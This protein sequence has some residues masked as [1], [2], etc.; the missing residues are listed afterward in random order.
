MKNRLPEYYE[1]TE[2]EIKDIWNNGTILL[3][4]N[5][6][7]NLFRYSKT[8]REEL[9]KIIKH[10]QDR[11]WLPYQVAFEFLE[12]AEGVPAS[13]SKALNETLK[14]IDALYGTIESQLKL[15]EYDKYHLLRPT[16]L[17][18]DIKKFQDAL[19]KRVEKIRTE[20]NDID[21]KAIVSEVTDIFSGKV[22][23]DYPEDKLEQ[24]FKDGD[25][26]YKEKTPP[27][28]K[29]L[30]DK[31]G[32]PKRHLYGDLIWWMQAIDYA[33]ANHCNL[34]IVTDDSKEDWWY[35]VEHETKS[36]RVELIKEFAKLT[37]G[38]SFHMYRTGRFMELAKKYDKVTISDKSI[39]EVKETSSIN[40]VN[41]FGRIA[42]PI[43]PSIWGT[44][45]PRSIGE[46]SIPTVG[47][48][49]Q[50]L[51]SPVASDYI[52]AQEL[53]KGSILPDGY[54]PSTGRTVSE[55][56][57]DYSALTPKDY[58]SIDTLSDNSTDNK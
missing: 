2:A 11:L 14:A 53:I 39:K 47:S 20:Y 49:L 31:K 24:L 28:Y 52:R 1:P 40:Y 42:K 46:I 35:R 27:G 43:D 30:E 4:A 55:I 41:L 32:A 51:V 3:D 17:R 50:S 29:D 58:I 22:G 44:T 37:D 21:K 18:N 12:N 15:N 45:V 54:I 5:V 9:I 48:E 56:L 33:K 36:P 6:L 16:E 23:E 38:Q 7:L 26:R 57:A 25:K 34:V 13:L 10:Y 8:S 19:R